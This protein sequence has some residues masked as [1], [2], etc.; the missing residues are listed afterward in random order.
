MGLPVPGN[1]TSIMLP[2]V[3]LIVPRSAEFAA[4]IGYTWHFA[5]VD[6]ALWWRNSVAV[7]SRY[8]GAID[9]LTV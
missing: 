7:L 2:G 6:M 3:S 9:L 4:P 1:V 5:A 8:S